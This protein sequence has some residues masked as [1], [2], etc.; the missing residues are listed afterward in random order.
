[1]H[2]MNKNNIRTSIG[3]KIY[4][5]RLSASGFSGRVWA[6]AVACAVMNFWVVGYAQSYSSQDD[7]ELFPRPAVVNEM[8][9]FWKKIYTDV[10]LKEGL[11]HD[12]D[13]PS[14][15]YAKLRVGERHGRSRRHF[16]RE[17]KDRIEDMLQA[18]AHKPAQQWST[19]EKKIA[20][21]VKTHIP[22]H[23]RAGAAHRIR[24]QRGQRERFRRGLERSGAYL[25]TIR[26]ILAQRGVPGRLCFLPH[27]ESSFNTDAYSKVGAAGMWQFMRSTGRRYLRIDYL[28]DERRDPIHSSEAAAKLL[29]TNYSY[30]KSWPLAITAYNHGR[31]GM[32]R[33]VRQVGSRNIED[34]IDRYRS[35]S[36]RFSSKNFYACFLAASDVAANYSRYFGEIEFEP[37]FHATTF[38]LP[39][40]VSLDLFVKALN[41]SVSTFREYNPALR[42]AI[43]DSH[44]R[45]PAQY[46]YNIPADISHESA[47][48]AFNS[49]PDSL[50]YAK[51]PTPR[52]YKVRRGDNLYSISRRLEVSM[53][54]LALA[55]DIVH[56]GRIY[57]GQVLRVP[58]SEKKT[59]RNTEI[60]SDN[61]N[62]SKPDKEET[63]SS[64]KIAVDEGM[65]EGGKKEMPASWLKSKEPRSE[66]QLQPHSVVDTTA[67]AE[68][69]EIDFVRFDAAIYNL[70]ATMDHTKGYASITVSI[71][72]TLGHYADW[73][74]IA[75]QRIR[76]ANRMGYR[77]QIHI[78]DEIR[79]PVQEDALAEFNARRL[80]YHMAIEED[81]YSHFKIV[82]AVHKRIEGG[83]NLWQI[84][85][86]YSRTP[87]WL[88]KKLNP[89]LR[90]EE[91]LIVGMKI[92]LPLI[93]ARSQNDYARI[94]EKNIPA[95][96][97]SIRISSS[98]VFMVP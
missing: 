35:R 78:G 94:K 52:Y 65:Q 72:E 95:A 17:K 64:A 49:I 45:L 14:V 22:A 19:E 4:R 7:A 29:K 30:L 42:R 81:F 89:G 73:L 88:F 77:S 74:G 27:V 87:V 91:P 61:T 83:D 36:F 96:D 37:R 32:Q 76:N 47:R 25:D 59:R 39:E 54:E 71:N 79:I 13:Y 84:C 44:R 21:L 5:Y 85:N 90:L 26:T 40:Y 28:I 12:R 3:R 31:Y 23:D 82:D 18:I 70:A 8:V 50:R 75:T 15:I 86:E 43:Y 97:R 38:T 33:A 2:T 9:V 41:I 24:F 66:K 20:K 92:W 80:E 46:T 11:L 69:G 62:R 51:L 58:G 10:S 6:A 57:P 67:G 63:V 60:V 53:Q 16:I 34:I 93:E 56:T 55:N 1:M 98:P 68:Y 48:M